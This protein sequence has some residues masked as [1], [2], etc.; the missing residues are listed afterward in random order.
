MTEAVAD[1]IRVVGLIRKQVL[2]RRI[3]WI[4]AATIAYNV[5]EAVIA[6]SA[7]TVASSAALFGFGLDSIVEV[8][9]AAAVAWQF[10]APDPEKREKVALRVIAW[11]FF[12]LAAYVTVDAGLSLF[13]L[14]EAE[15]SPVGIVLAAVSL[16]VMPFLSL[17]ERRAGR[18]LGSASAIADSKQ[19]LICSYLSAALLVGLLLNTL[20][21]WAWADSVAALV[22]VVFAVREGLEAWRGDACKVPV[23]A[24]TGERDIQ[25]CDC[26]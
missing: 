21:G 25:A 7:G 3:R 11:S 19:T 24:L 10:A 8:L 13:G 5:I 4:V 1:R 15:H 23:S 12:A 20:L 22:I 14:R 26:C 9:S 18:E 6:I 16:A 17:A 2:R